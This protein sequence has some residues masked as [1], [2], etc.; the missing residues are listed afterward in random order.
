MKLDKKGVMK[1]GIFKTITNNLDFFAV[2]INNNF[3]GDIRSL[4]IRKK[5][6][7]KKLEALFW[8][9]SISLF[10]SK[11][12]IAPKKVYLDLNYTNDKDL[13]LFEEDIA[14][15]FSRFHK[16]IPLISSHDSKEQDCIALSDL[17]SGFLMRNK[18]L[19][20]HYKDKVR[21][22]RKEDIENEL[23]FLFKL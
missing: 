8:Y 1:A 9:K 14:L 12:N 23:K 7:M 20:T 5:E 18:E 21:I 15:L 17:L 4:V 11:T 19:F 16:I 10:C 13:R 3:Y 2:T 22:L 6:Y